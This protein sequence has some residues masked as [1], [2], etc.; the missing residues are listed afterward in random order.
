MPQVAQDADQACTFVAEH[1]DA[2][3]CPIEHNR[4]GGRAGMISLL[5]A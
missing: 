3:Q 5:Q 2:E 4:G 1:A